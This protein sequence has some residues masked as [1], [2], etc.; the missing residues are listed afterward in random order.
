[1]K[2]A[3]KVKTLIHL[4]PPPPLFLNKFTP[5]SNNYLRELKR[6][7]DDFNKF[8]LCTIIHAQTA[9]YTESLG[10]MAELVFEQILPKKT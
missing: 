1:M 5:H 8:F 4:P 2:I 10:K 3:H 6:P 9:E 7:L